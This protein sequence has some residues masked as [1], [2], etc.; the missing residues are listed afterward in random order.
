MCV[1]VRPCVHIRVCMCVC[2]RPCVHIRVCVCSEGEE[3]STE[4]AEEKRE[5]SPQDQVAPVT[6]KDPVMED[7][8]GS[9]FQRSLSPNSQAKTFLA[10]IMA[11]AAPAVSPLSSLHCTSHTSPHLTA[12]H[13]TGSHT[14]HY[15]SLHFTSHTLHYI[16][17]HISR[18]SLHL[19]ALHCT[20]PHCTSL[21]QTALNCT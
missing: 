9:P 18:T 15:I 13:F 8:S 21:H 1:Y 14:L 4:Q 3:C 17:L 5:A 10:H 6:Q 2:V 7:K 20:A 16:S 11:K 19:T 12:L